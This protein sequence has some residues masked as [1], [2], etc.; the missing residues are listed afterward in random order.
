MSTEFYWRDASKELPPPW[1]HVL[2]R[3]GRKMGD[4]LFNMHQGYD[5][6]YH[7]PAGD[8]FSYERWENSPGSPIAHV[9]YWMPL[10]APPDP[11]A[12]V[13]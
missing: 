8:H 7:V 11:P 2:I 3:L 9:D 13:E 10:P 12:E 1:Q 4:F 5:L 6:G